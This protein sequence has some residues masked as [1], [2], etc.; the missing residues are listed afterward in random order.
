MPLTPAARSPVQQQILKDYLTQLLATRRAQRQQN[1]AGA[2]G[3]QIE[4][5]RELYAIG[6]GAI[7]S[8]PAAPSPLLR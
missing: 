7:A 3:G 5:N 4:V 6:P 8:P 2:G 1:P